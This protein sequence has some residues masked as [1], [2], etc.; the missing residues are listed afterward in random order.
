MPKSETLLLHDKGIPQEDSI[1]TILDKCEFGTYESPV[2]VQFAGD[3]GVD[4]LSSG[5]QKSLCVQRDV[6]NL[7][8]VQLSVVE[9][10]NNTIDCRTAGKLRSAML[11]L[12]RAGAQGIELEVPGTGQPFVLI[13]TCIAGSEPRYAEACNSDYHNAVLYSHGLYSD[14]MNRRAGGF[15]IYNLQFSIFN[16]QFTIDDVRLP[17]VRRRIFDTK[18]NRRYMSTK[19]GRL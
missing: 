1:C 18:H 17:N 9:G 2:V 12:H 5:P 13:R 7:S 10:D 19:A 6:I 4:G 16:F 3:P 15:I 14:S 11:E 8:R